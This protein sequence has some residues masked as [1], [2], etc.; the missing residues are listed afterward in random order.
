M[1]YALS[2][3]LVGNCSNYRTNKL[4]NLLNV[5][6]AS[7]MKKLNIADFNSVL[8]G[9]FLTVVHGATARASRQ[10]LPETFKF[11]LELLRLVQD[12]PIAKYESVEFDDAVHKVLVEEV[13]EEWVLL[14]ATL[15]M[16]QGMLEA[17]SRYYKTEVVTV[18]IN[19]RL[20]A[21][22]RKIPNEPLLGILLKQISG[23][24]GMNDAIGPYEPDLLDYQ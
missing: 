5:V 2:L 7:E 10:F 16:L 19:G 3:L 13:R 12:K 9:Y 20:E 17:N 24:C 21:L 4:A 8:T 23:S 1:F 14:K 6:Y 11:V 22:A 15:K 18:D